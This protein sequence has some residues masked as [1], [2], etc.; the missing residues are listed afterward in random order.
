MVRLTSHGARVTFLVL[1]LT[2]SVLQA[3]T[4]APAK[5]AVNQDSLVIATFE[6]KIKEYMKLH[7]KAKAGIHPLKPTDSAHIINEEQRLLAS[8]I[9]EA[10]SEAKA[11]DIFTPEVSQVFKLLIARTMEGPQAT[12]IRATLRHAEPVSKVPL[13]VDATYPEHLP[14]QSSPPSLLLNLPEL[15]PELDYRI[16]GRDLVLRDA[17]ADIIVDFITNAIPSS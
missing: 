1:V 11:G 6:S 7:N 10:R 3:Q 15:P 5:P 14:L 2:C 13:Q 17:G 4:A 12:E 9:R 16:V 8:R